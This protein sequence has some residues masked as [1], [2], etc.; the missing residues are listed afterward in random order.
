MLN[1][2]ENNLM[3]NTWLLLIL[4]TTSLLIPIAATAATVPEDASV[5]D[6]DP[7][8]DDDGWA[9]SV[10]S[11]DCLGVGGLNAH[12]FLTPPDGNN[13]GGGVQ[14]SGVPGIRET[15]MKSYT[16]LVSGGQYTVEWY[17]MRD[18]VQGTGEAAESWFEVTLCSDQQDSL[19]LTP[20]QL[21]SWTQDS[22]TFTADATSCDLSFRARNTTGD[23]SSW[24]FVDGVSIDGSAIDSVPVPATSRTGIL[25]LVIMLMTA[26]LIA[27]RR[28]Y[29][30]KI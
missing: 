10:G 30:L 24:V 4:V 26:G 15:I 2:L 19:R 13:Y 29:G 17:I 28:G 25:L 9:N 23:N 8:Y 6:M 16:N 1:V 7:C 27:R 3:K 12:V 5:N 22:L 14:Y 21:R 20:S 18:T 11:F